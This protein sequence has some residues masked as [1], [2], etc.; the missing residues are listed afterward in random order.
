MIAEVT[1]AQAEITA[2]CLEV[3]KGQGSEDYSD[4]FYVI[5]TL[6]QGISAEMLWDTYKDDPVKTVEDDITHKS[7]KAMIEKARN[8]VDEAWAT[9]V[10]F[11]ITKE[12]LATAGAAE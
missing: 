6:W 4:A 2:Q 7:M 8:E 9:L 10:P 5:G 12:H 3:T 11:G 1:K